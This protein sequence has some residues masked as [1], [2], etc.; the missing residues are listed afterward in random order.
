M[1]SFTTN[2]VDLV[3]EPIAIRAWSEKRRTH[4][5]LADER[6]MSFPASR[7]K[8]LKDASD[9]ALAQIQLRLNGKALRWENLDEDLTVKGIIAG[10][11]QL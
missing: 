4:I 8:I 3:A 10:K 5:E 2:E 11:F 9:E 6:I 7:F 1:L